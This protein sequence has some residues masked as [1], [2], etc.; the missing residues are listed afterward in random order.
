[1]K[2]FLGKI[3]MHVSRSKEHIQDT[4]IIFKNVGSVE[5]EDTSVPEVQLLRLWKET[6]RMDDNIGQMMTTAE[7]K[8]QKKTPTGTTVG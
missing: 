1:M 2:L 6:Q 8:R 5:I 4:W 7:G 3:S